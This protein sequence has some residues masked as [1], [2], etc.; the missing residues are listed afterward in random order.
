MVEIK[1]RVFKQRSIVLCQLDFG[2]RVPKTNHMFQDDETLEDV[3]DI[4]YV[5]KDKPGP[6]TI[7][8]EIIP[9]DA[10]SDA[11]LRVVGS[12]DC[13]GYSLLFA[14]TYISRCSGL[15]HSFMYI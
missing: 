10:F 8:L 3:L 1:H 14:F 11:R 15:C 12:F 13:H 7:E 6:Q 9:L 5:Y 4:L 2:I